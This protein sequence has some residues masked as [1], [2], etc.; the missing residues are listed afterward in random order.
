MRSKL[1]GLA[2][3]LAV[4]AVNSPAGAEERAAHREDEN[5]RLDGEGDPEVF[6][7]EGTNRL[8]AGNAAGALPLLLRAAEGLST[9][10][11]AWYNLGM[12]AIKVED[13]N[14]ACRALARADE[15]EPGKPDTEI[16][17]GIALSKAGRCEESVTVLEHTVKDDPSR[18]RAQYYLYS[19][20]SALGDVERAATAL[21]RYNQ[22]RSGS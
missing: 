4:I 1:W 2:A 7:E 10:P 15:L 16:N 8:A 22:G 20:Y 6:F 9:Q 3:A 19:C 21:Q 17:L 14:V 18:Y 5:R 12:A 11:V 13:W